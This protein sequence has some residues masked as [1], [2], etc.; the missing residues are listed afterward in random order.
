MDKPHHSYFGVQDALWNGAETEL[1]YCDMPWVLQ[2]H[3]KVDKS[4]E[5]HA[6]FAGDIALLHGNDC[7]TT[8]L[9]MGLCVKQ[10]VGSKRSHFKLSHPVESRAPDF[11]TLNA[12]TKNMKTMRA[13]LAGDD[14]E[15]QLKRAN[16]KFLASYFTGKKRP[17]DNVEQVCAAKAAKTTT[18]AET[19]EGPTTERTDVR[20][21]R[22]VASEPSLYESR[23]V[24]VIKVPRYERRTDRATTLE[25]P[26]EAPSK[27]KSRPI[28]LVKC[29][30]NLPVS[31]DKLKDSCLGLHVAN[32]NNE[33]IALVVKHCDAALDLPAGYT[34]HKPSIRR[35][36]ATIVRN[37]WSAIS[38]AN[39]VSNINCQWQKC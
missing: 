34:M 7:T 31:F 9:H 8:P 29:A 30:D 24:K 17:L 11:L 36:S 33:V 19:V 37:I 6:R 18:A 23:G 27:G 21:P 39:C 5:D 16:N 4:I 15:A 20:G 2:N 26:P 25:L 1:E 14:A 35:V 32:V 38:S 13:D 22:I 3:T 12:F 28:L 10:L